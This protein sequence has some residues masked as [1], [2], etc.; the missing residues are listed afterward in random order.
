MAPKAK[1]PFHFDTTNAADFFETT[2]KTL[3]EWEKTAGKENKSFKV[4]Y[5][6]YHL[7]KLHTWWLENIHESKQETK[8]E[9]DSRERYWA[10]KAELSELDVAT[11]RGLLFPQADLLPEWIKVYSEFRQGGLGLGNILPAL[12]EGKSTEE[13]RTIINSKVYELLTA[14]ARPGE[15]RP[16]P[17]VKVK[18]TKK[19]ATPKKKKATLKKKK[20]KK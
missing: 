2:P 3:S 5:G 7:K 14:L 11:K 12:L 13:M 1:S 10:A 17:I 18:T 16:A 19:K 15:L 6:I 4:A 8:V 9:V 20:A